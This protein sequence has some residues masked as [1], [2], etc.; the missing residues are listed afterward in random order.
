MCSIEDTIDRSWIGSRNVWE[1]VL[2]N[3]QVCRCPDDLADERTAQQLDSP[4]QPEIFTLPIFTLR[5]YVI[6]SRHL[7]PVIMRQART[8]SFQPF[9][10]IASKVWCDASDHFMDMHE[11]GHPWIRDIFRDTRTALA[12]GEALDYQNM[13]TGRSLQKIID[14]LDQQV[15]SAG[16]KKLAL[17]S[18]VHHLMSVAPTDG[19]Y[20]KNNPFR[21]SKVEKDYW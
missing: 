13:L 9:T 17:Y 16:K 12:P 3:H 2:R 14:E 20:G 19:V 8:L 21:D 1:Q 10:K 18:W 11:E 7:F 15:H 4:G 6:N 5:I